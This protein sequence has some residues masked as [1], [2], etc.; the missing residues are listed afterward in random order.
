MSINRGIWRRALRSSNE[1]AAAGDGIPDTWQESATSHPG[2][3]RD[4]KSHP[5]FRNPCPD[6]TTLTFDAVAPDLTDPPVT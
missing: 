2:R 1:L 4:P 3:R 5:A 6:T